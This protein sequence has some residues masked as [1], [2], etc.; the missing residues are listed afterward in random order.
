[1][2]FTDAE[3]LGMPVAV[4]IGRGLANGMVEIRNRRTGEKRE[5]S[6][7]DAVAAVREL[8]GD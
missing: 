2:K 7:A 8:A 3:L 4:V 5:V 1:M 6:V